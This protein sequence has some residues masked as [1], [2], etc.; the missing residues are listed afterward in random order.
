VIIGNPST[1]VKHFQD[2]HIQIVEIIR[3]IWPS[4]AGRFNPQ[5][6]ENKITDQ[7]VLLLQRHPYSRKRWIIEPQHKLLDSDSNGDVVTKGFID[8]VLFFTLDQEIYIAYE[9]KRL[10]VQFPSGFQTLAD[11]YVDEGVMRY[12]S[13]QY[14]QDLPFCVMIGYVL[15][16]NTPKA[17]DAVKR[18]IKSKTGK[19]LCTSPIELPSMS[20]I[21]RF[22]TVH[23]RSTQKIE[24]EHLFL[25]LQP[26]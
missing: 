7:L 19:L 24:I 2:I 13:A 17:L 26:T 8:F 16:S 9:C 15:D 5:S 12:V 23:D 3:L 25:P 18:Q 21:H 11:K 20:F 14:A 22:S 1:W 10:N 4:C 6:E